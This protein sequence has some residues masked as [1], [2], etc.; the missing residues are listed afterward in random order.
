MKHMRFCV[1]FC[2]MVSA[3]VPVSSL[4]QPRAF[5][6]HLIT[7][8]SC[9]S[10]GELCTPWYVNSEELRDEYIRLR[11]RATTRTLVQLA[12]QAEECMN[13][14]PSDKDLQRLESVKCLGTTEAHRAIARAHHEHM[15]RRLLMYNELLQYHTSARIRQHRSA[16]PSALAIEM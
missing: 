5:Q 1:P 16:T 4:A 15:H 12:R 3:I 13:N 2:T 7:P 11:E 6:P 9:N 8:F 10:A 14:G